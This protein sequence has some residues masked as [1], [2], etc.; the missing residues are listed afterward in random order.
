MSGKEV[1]LYDV[2]S[3]MTMEASIAKG[4]ITLLGGMPQENSKGKKKRL[5]EDQIMLGFASL[6]DGNVIDACFGVTALTKKDSPARKATQDAKM[7]LIDAVDN[8]EDIRKLAVQTYRTAFRIVVTLDER[9][10]KL[11]CFTR[12]FQYGKIQRQA[13]V[14]MSE[15]F[16]KLQKAVDESK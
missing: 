14:A 7:V 5:T 9:V 13:E 12:C 10:N 11:N 3:L 4:Y 16:D 1:R 6:A 8:N 15:A 2:A